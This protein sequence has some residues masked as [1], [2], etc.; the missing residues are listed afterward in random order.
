M[1][2]E[3]QYRK[4]HPDKLMVRCRK[5]NVLNITGPTI[6]K[7]QCI[8]CCSEL[9]KRYKYISEFHTARFLYHSNARYA[10]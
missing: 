2:T 6:F 3:I 9:P 8:V 4:T 10:S 1:V 7:R 5:C